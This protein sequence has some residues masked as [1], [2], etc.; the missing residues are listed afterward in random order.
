MAESKSKSN[1]YWKWGAYLVILVS[2]FA[3]ISSLPLNSLSSALKDW[4]DSLG[5]WGPITLGLIYIIATII[6]VPGTLLTLVAGAVFGLGLGF[7]TVSIAST[8]GAS[9]AFLIARYFARDKVASMA[10]DNRHFDAIDA[11]IEEGGWKVV[12]LLRL[13]PAIP[14][15]VQNYLYG[16]TKVKFWEYVLTSWIA[17]MPG[18]FMYIYLG[19]VS[20]AALG[21]DREKSPFEWVLMVVGLLATVAVTVYVTKLAKSKLDDDVDAE[22][23]SDESD[24]DD[25]TNGENSKSESEDRDKKKSN[26]S[27][28]KSAFPLMPVIVAGLMLIVAGGVFLNKEAIG[29]S[30]SGLAGPPA[31]EMKESYATIPDGPSVDHSAFDELLKKHVD[32]DG[33]VDYEGFKTDS[34]TLDQYIKSLGEAPIKELG[35]NHRLATLINAYNAFTIKLILDHQPL[36]SIN[37]IPPEHRWDAL[38]WKLGDEMYSL[39]QIEHE[40][41][42]PHFKEPRIHF[43]VVCAAVGCPPLRNEAYAF[44]R[45]E[46]QLEEQAQYVHDHKTWFQF[47][48]GEEAKVKLTRLY[49]WYGGDFKQAAKTELKYA[50]QYSKELKSYLSNEDNAKP[51]QEWLEYDWSLNSKSNK[52]QR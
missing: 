10:K 21:G 27:D 47:T 36:N 44:D 30:L 42:R 23:G 41:I 3:I 28:E 34:D 33:W 8:I 7:I 35:R 9:L 50:A 12:G 20:G 38:R 22:V 6:F 2:L 49:K 15:N 39:S 40:R 17:M 5:I 19:T 43:A 4:I 11:A 45:L 51:A 1:K 26:K 13:S 25:E 31:V 48:G 52:E 32:A 16:L 18:T 24:S 46:E 14:F 29:K 37:D